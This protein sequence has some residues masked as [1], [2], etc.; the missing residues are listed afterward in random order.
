MWSAYLKASF[1]LHFQEPEKCIIRGDT[2]IFQIIQAFL[3]CILHYAYERD[4]LI[5]YHYIWNY[6]TQF[7]AYLIEINLLMNTYFDVNIQILWLSY[8]PKIK[9]LVRAW[10]EWTLTTQLNIKFYIIRG[11]LRLITT[12]SAPVGAILVTFY[13]LQICWRI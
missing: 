13:W 3:I 10:N 12:I 6:Q 1:L 8:S 9:K 2:L 7:E 5:R 4:F 11:N